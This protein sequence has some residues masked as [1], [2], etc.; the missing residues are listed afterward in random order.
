MKIRAGSVFYFITFFLFKKRMR[1]LTL[2]LIDTIAS[3]GESDSYFKQL[4][5]VSREQIP[6]PVKE[7]NMNLH[8]Q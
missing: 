3:S 5:L 7:N 1:T 8:N 2:I 4:S 6:K